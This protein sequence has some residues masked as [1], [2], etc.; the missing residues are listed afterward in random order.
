MARLEIEAAIDTL[1]T[2]GTY[3]SRCAE[4]AQVFADYRRSSKAEELIDAMLA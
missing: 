1:L 4:M 2:D 3:R